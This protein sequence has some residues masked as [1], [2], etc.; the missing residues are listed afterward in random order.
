MRVEVRI[1]KSDNNPHKL[2]YRCL[3]KTTCDYFKWWVLERNDFNNGAVF[4]GIIGA[5]MDCDTLS[6]IESN[7]KEVKTIMK[8]KL[9]K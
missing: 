4:E 2:Y 1:S 3:N 8:K 7:V 9:Q 5:I 6:A